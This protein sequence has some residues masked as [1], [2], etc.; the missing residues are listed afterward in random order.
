MPP[1][2]VVLHST[3]HA[4]GGAAGDGVSPAK[5]DFGGAFRAVMALLLLVLMPL[6]WC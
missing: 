3:A 4:A 6:W 5:A 2:V 1:I